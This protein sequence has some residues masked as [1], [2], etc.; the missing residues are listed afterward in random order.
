[1]TYIN[2]VHKLTQ[3]IPKG[4]VTTYGSI[5]KVLRI[6]PRMVGYA[7]H[8]NRSSNIP[9]HRVVN[10]VGRVAQGFAFGGPTEQ[11]RRLILEGVLFKSELNVDLEKCFVFA[12][13]S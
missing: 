6:N 4:K 13:V 2:D 9:C 1:M 5:A 3:R 8:Q 11:K 12:G 10:R 7:L